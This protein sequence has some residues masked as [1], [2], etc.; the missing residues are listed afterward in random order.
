MATETALDLAAE[1]NP[2]DIKARAIGACVSMIQSVIMRSH[3]VDD[4]TRIRGSEAE[5]ALFCRRNT[6][7]AK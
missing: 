5:V 6:A 3:L 4:A 7:V 2:T 1:Q